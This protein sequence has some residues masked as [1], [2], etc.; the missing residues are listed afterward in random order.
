MIITNII[1]GLGNQLFQYAFHL[2]LKKNIPDQAHYL[3]ICDFE[4]YTLHSGYLLEK[5]FNIEEQ[6]TDKA[7]LKKFEK[8]SLIKRVGNKTK[9]TNHQIFFEKNI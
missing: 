1:G 6:Y 9:M 8:N 4:N 5:V 2:Y 3:N 7:I